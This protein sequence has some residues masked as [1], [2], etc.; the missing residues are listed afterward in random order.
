MH[1]ETATYLMKK[2]QGDP[3]GNQAAGERRQHGKRNA[4]GERVAGD[5]YCFDGHRRPRPRRR[6][7][8]SAQTRAKIKVPLVPPNPNEFDSAAR[9]SIGRASR[10]T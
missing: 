9:I 2:R 4:R 6:E 3:E 10:G 1:P 8:A 7:V 5:E